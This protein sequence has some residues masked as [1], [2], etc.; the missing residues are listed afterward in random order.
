MGLIAVQ[1]PSKTRSLQ[2]PQL[3]IRGGRRLSGELQ[4][5]GA[6]N[7]A[8]VLMAAC[9]LTRE[10]IRL[11]N[12]PP[13]TDIAAMGEMLSSL[14]GQ[15]HRDG[16]ALELKGDSINS[17]TAPYELVNSLRASFFCIGPLLARTGMAK[18]PLPG[19]CQIGTRPVVEHVKGL[20]ALGAQV[21]IEHGVVTAVVPGSGHRLTGGRIHMDCPSVGAT[22]TL[23]MAAALADGETV[24]D[25]AALEPE[26]VDLAGLLIAMGAKVRGAGTSTIT[27]VG[28]DRLH[29]A[30]YAVIPDRIEAGTFLLAAAI[31][32]SHLR[33]TP[34][35]PDH[36]GAVLTKLEEAGCTLE[37][38]GVG[39]TIK[40]DQ[41]NAVDLR[42]QPFPGFPTDL[43]APFMSL[44]ATARGTSVITENIFENRLQH[45]G[46]LQRMGAAIRMQGNTAF[47]EG[48]VRLSGAPVQGSDLR[49]SAAM[50]LA[51]LAADGI[52]SVRGLEY[53]DRGYANLEGKLNAAGA[54]IE[55]V[56]SAA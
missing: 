4:V 40:A 55:R 23:M 43:Q 18:V 31:T 33:V 21:T 35:I 6:K 24:I 41:I 7:S 30:D 22:E 37:H 51:G 42:T 14:G 25:N 47:V 38:D 16:D 44:L 32:R 17:S 39:L 28:V 45:V 26:V 2:N 1:S 9:L 13:L 12:V 52:T 5:S 8:L 56:C 54:S 29:G 27:I 36:L 19:G 34:V 50:V 15:V 20:K 53:L 46:E 3:E 10:T 49:A 11:R 48:V